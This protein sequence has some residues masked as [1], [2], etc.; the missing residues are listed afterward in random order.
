[1]TFIG[2]VPPTRQLSNDVKH[3]EILADSIA[4]ILQG[5]VNV[6][7]DVTV[8]ASATFYEVLDPRLHSFVYVDIMP[9]SSAATTIKNSVYYTSAK[10]GSITANFTAP[11]VNSDIRFLIV[12]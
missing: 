10:R 4:Y 12:G 1:M 8:S 9:L 7:L 11:G 5:R 6:T 3:R 2:Y